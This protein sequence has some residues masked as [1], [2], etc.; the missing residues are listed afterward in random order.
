MQMHIT[1]TRSDKTI[2]EENAYGFLENNP[3]GPEI[4]GS[5]KEVGRHK[6]GIIVNVRT[7]ALVDLRA[8]LFIKKDAGRA[9]MD[10]SKKGSNETMEKAILSAASRPNL[11]LL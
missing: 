3:S 4:F 2:H 7:R 10:T 9:N 5:Q 8:S 6:R 1:K 11:Y